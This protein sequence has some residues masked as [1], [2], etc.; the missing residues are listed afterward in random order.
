MP[1][2]IHCTLGF[3][4]SLKR[5]VPF[6]IIIGLVAADALT[7]IAITAAAMVQTCALLAEMFVDPE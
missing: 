5:A 7:V 2:R 4:I 3:C 1:K 6:V